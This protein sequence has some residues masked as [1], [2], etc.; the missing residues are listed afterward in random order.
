MNIKNDM[1]F[2]FLYIYNKL[3]V[4]TTEQIVKLIKIKVANII[5]YNKY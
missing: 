2:S 1:Y 5:R 3:F 4:F